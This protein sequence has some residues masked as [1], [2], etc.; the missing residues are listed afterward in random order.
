MPTA[1]IAYA[2]IDPNREPPPTTDSWG[3]AIEQVYLD[4]HQPPHQRPRLQQLLQDCIASPPKTLIIRQLIDLGDSL[5]EILTCI[6]TLEALNLSVFALDYPDAHPLTVTNAV[7][8]HTLSQ[9]IP[10]LLQQHRRQQLQAGHARNRI[11]GLPPPGRAPYGYRRGRDRYALDRSTAPVVKAFFEQF[12]LFGSLRGAVRYLEKTYGKR[13]SASTGQR[14][15]TH[16]V[17]RG[18][19]LYNDG[20]VLRDTHTPIISREEAA[21]ID[22]LLRRNRRF[23]PKT[24][25]AQRS[26]AGLVQCQECH[27]ALQVARVTRPHHSQDYVYL[28][29]AHCSRSAARCSAI[30]YDAVLSKTIE[31][32]CQELPKAV[33]TL[34]APPVSSIKKGIAA[35]IQQKEAILSQIPD[36]L[37]QG[38][39]DEATANLRTYT[40]RSELAHL[41]QQVSQ[42]PPENLQQI[43][44]T[45]SIREF[46]DDLSEAERRV[47][48]REF[49]HKALIIRCGDRWDV[50]IEF[51]F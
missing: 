46:W 38:I 3:Q 50:Q 30:P 29:P 18:D 48:L 5:G 7:D 13:I 9:L 31:R 10:H 14:W 23:S 37:H 8:R 42:L 43:V 26:L 22:R 15:L 21:Q 20:H 12:L 28:R 19:L 33:A 32:V 40:L 41:Q 11:Q 17:Y 34:P 16:P 44:Q 24:A 36:L 1:A 6:E 2:C 47:Y 35:N 39:L 51:V 27:S 4:Y 25:S 49:I 45:L